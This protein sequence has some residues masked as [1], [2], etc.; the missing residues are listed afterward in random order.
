MSFHRYEEYKGHNNEEIKKLQRKIWDY[1][2]KIKEAEEEIYKIQS[3]C[4]HHYQF[5]STGPYEDN[6]VCSLCGHDTEH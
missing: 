1:E 6:Y 5:S 3:A 4:N 2:K